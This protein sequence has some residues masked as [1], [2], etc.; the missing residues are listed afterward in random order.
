M[1]YI[2]IHQHQIPALGLGTWDLRGSVAVDMVKAA[3]S[4][5]YRHI[6]TAQ[7]YENE[8]QVGQAINQSEVPR[9][10]VFLTTK[11][12][13]SNL[14]KSTFLQSVQASLQRLS[15]DYVDLLLIHWPNPDIPLAESLEALQAAQEQGLTRL[16]GV[17]N[18]PV[19]LL[20]ESLDTGI[21]LSMNQVEYHPF[22]QQDTLRS[23]M[24]EQGIALTAYSPIAKAKVI[25]EPAIE[26]I[27]QKYGKSAV[28][29]TLRWL[30]QHGDVA[31]IPRT[32]NPQR[33]M[34]NLHIF[35][36]A[37]NEAEMHVIS[38]LG[39]KNLRLVSPQNGPAWDA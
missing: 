12:W 10:A 34:Q 15:L 13:P 8:S 14:G 7:F 30:V 37:L 32:S 4:M 6:D 24:R 18:F 27:A 11:V 22:L 29:V 23:Y 5:G 1:K 25:G 35:D 31:A 19:Q 33:L 3:L 16:I 26:A 21:S 9:S 28:Q 36:F 17:S 38:S 39:V 2:D 20:K